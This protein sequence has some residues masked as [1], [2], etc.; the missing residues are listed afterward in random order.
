MVD[1][2]YSHFTYKGSARKGGWNV[3]TPGSMY[4]ITESGNRRRIAK[5]HIGKRKIKRN[6]DVERRILDPQALKKVVEDQHPGIITPFTIDAHEYIL[7]ARCGD[8]HGFPFTKSQVKIAMFQLVD[9]LQHMHNDLEVVH[10]D[11]KP[12]N[13]VLRDDGTVGFID[14][15]AAVSIASKEGSYSTVL[16]RSPEFYSETYFDNK[17]AHDIWSLAISMIEL[18]DENIYKKDYRNPIFEVDHEKN[19]MSPVKMHAVLKGVFEKL[20]EKDSAFVDVIQQLLDLDPKKR[21]ENFSKIRTHPYFEGLKENAYDN[22]LIDVDPVPEALEENYQDLKG[23]VNVLRKKIAEIKKKVESPKTETQDRLELTVLRHHRNEALL[24]MAALEEQNPR[25][26]GEI[27]EKQASDTQLTQLL[28]PSIDEWKS[29]LRQVYRNKE[30]ID[31][32]HEKIFTLI[33]AYHEANNDEQKLKIEGELKEI[34]GKN[35]HGDPIIKKLSE[36]LMIRRNLVEQDQNIQEYLD[37]Y[38]NI[39]KRLINVLEEFVAAKGYFEKQ[40]KFDRLLRYAGPIIKKYSLSEADQEL[41]AILKNGLVIMKSLSQ[42]AD[43][44]KP[45]DWMEMSGRSHKRGLLTLKTKRRGVTRD[46]DRLVEKYH[47]PGQ[48]KYDVAEQIIAKCDQYLKEHEV[49]SRTDA[50][51]ALKQSAELALGQPTIPSVDEWS[52]WVKDDNAWNIEDIRPISTQIQHF[53]GWDKPLASDEM[54]QLALDN[55]KKSAIK[56]IKLCNAFLD[57][58]E[59]KTDLTRAVG[60]LLNKA[61]EYLDAEQAMELAP[62]DHSQFVG[63]LGLG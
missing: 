29:I 53:Q 23:Y 58:H 44:P 60:R 43:I 3:V 20:K 51:L 50:I 10:L 41:E 33:R 15:D 1:F 22:K 56:M 62:V 36:L 14:F 30:K 25:L 9:S 6:Q 13:M 31:Q 5:R 55:K 8:L 28:M 26:A 4:L 48:S 12:L 2:L 37:K 32:Q 39:D 40:Q 61:I 35:P 34:V 38:P 19:L 46:I 18:F 49:T 54:R 59:E 21:L 11:I 7:F 24:R 27:E 52:A 63:N 16:Y 17:A 42:K 47:T 45:E 57:A